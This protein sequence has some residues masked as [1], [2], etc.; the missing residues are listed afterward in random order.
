LFGAATMHNDSGQWRR[1]AP[2]AVPIEHSAPKTESK[3]CTHS[4][5]HR[6][7]FFGKRRE[8]PATPFPRRTPN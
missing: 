3:S 8:S 7:H 5:R 4:Q 1:M 2:L 6:D